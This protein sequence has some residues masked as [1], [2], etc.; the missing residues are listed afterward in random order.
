MRPTLVTLP[1][2]A[3]GLGV[4]SYGLAIAVGFAIG[5]VLAA[6]EARRVGLDAGA[7][8][9]L[10][11]WI[12]VSGVLGSR[13]A[14][15][16]LH[17]GDYLQLCRQ[18][19]LPGCLAPL[20]LWEGG[21]VYY[22]GALAAT[23]AVALFARRRGWPFGQVA[24]VLAPA[25]ALGHA[26]GRL[27]CFFAGCCFGKPW[28][29]GLAF[30][31]GSVA[32]DDL[33]RTGVISA[34]APATPPL[35]PTQL[36]EALGELVIFLLLLRVRRRP[37]FAGAT[38]LLYAASYAGLRFAVE[39]FRGDAA[40]GFLVEAQ[41]PRLAALLGLPPLQPLFLST[42]QVTSLAV[43]AAAILLLVRGRAA[44]R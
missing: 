25:L 31:P 2:G 6:R 13:L 24:D 26:F 12:L 35:H 29:H 1:I 8:L 33:I 15:V 10:L 42:A 9:D 32:F 4:H 11:F 20:K 28:S 40:R 34:S 23:G 7:M 37:P 17:A 19:G 41:T 30:P 21:L 14:F 3:H 22:G 5:V 39:I 27:G 36:Y 38:A 18:G 16:L 43:G 44:A